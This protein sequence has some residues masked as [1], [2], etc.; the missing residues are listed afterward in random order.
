MGVRRGIHDAMEGKQSVVEVWWPAAA[1]DRKGVPR[2][3]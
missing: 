1:A 2:I 3:A